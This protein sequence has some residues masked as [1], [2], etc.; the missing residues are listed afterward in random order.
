MPSGPTV[1]VARG[2]EVAVVGWEL[3]KMKTKWTKRSARLRDAGAA[4]ALA[5]AA[6]LAAS[7]PAE[8]QPGPIA[9][10]YRPSTQLTSRSA[11]AS[12]STCSRQRLPTST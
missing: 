11:K 1:K 12:W 8:A 5:V 10:G 3:V 2:N 7:A 6:A 4:F 9:S